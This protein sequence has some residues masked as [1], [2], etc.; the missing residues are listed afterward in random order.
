MISKRGQVTIFV[1]IAIVIV[2]AVVLFFVLRQSKTQVNQV[3]SSF[4][5]PYSSFLGCLSDDTTLGVKILESQGG[6]IDPPNFEPGS[7]YMP[8]S[9]QLNFMGNIIPYWYYVSG[10]NMQKEQVPTV[11]EMESQLADFIDSKIKDCNLEAYSGGYN[12]LLGDPKADVKILSDRIEVGLKM[13]LSLSKSGDSTLVKNHQVTV[14]S[15]LGKLYN[16]AVVVYK[17]EQTELFL[18]NYSVDILGAYAP[19][20]GVELTCSPLTWDAEEVFNKLGEA[21]EAN[22]LALKSKGSD[23]DYFYVNLG[24]NENVRFLNSRNWTNSF[25]VNPSTGRLLISDPVGNQ[26]G[27]GILGFCYVA[28]HYVYDVKYPVLIQVYDGEEI[29]QFPV[30]VIIEGNKPREPLASLAVERQIPDLCQ[31]KNTLVD[32]AIYDS[33]DHPIDADVSYE[34]SGTS[35][36]IGKSNNG[37][38]SSEFP[39]CAGGRIITRAQGYKDTYTGYSVIEGGHIDVFMDKKYPLEVNLKLDGKSYSGEA[40]VSFISNDSSA[41]ILYPDQKSIELTPGEYNVEVYI[42]KN[43]TLKL[44]A[45]TT[46]EC[47]DVP[48]GGLAG[49]IGLKEKKCFDVEVPEQIISK[50]LSGGGKAQVYVLD[51]TLARSTKVEINSESLPIPESLEQLQNNYLLFEDKVLEVDFT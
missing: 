19:V 38:L 17:K 33:S 42:Y 22:T 49:L 24:V 32:V 50:A 28:Y 25:E 20:D 26:P 10:N 40:V 14:P 7:S 35:C 13:D 12:I 6:Y 41:T 2:A 21:I 30:A 27:L 46:Q 45:S 23:K 3:S 48:K 31:Y 36:Y 29:F 8:F 39:Q 1:I 37:I 44:G 5:A 9:S 18:E 51:N 43:S 47:V 15:S 11:T 34:C 4:E 16:S